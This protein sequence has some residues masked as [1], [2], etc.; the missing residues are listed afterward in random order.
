MN[1]QEKIEKLGWKI[2]SCFPV[3][4]KVYF[5]TKN[6]NSVRASSLSELLRKIKSSVFFN[7]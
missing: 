4:G 6:N 5:A 7:N 2:F 3:T 1:T